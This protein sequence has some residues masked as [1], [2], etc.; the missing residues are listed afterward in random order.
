MY[1]IKEL[2]LHQHD[3]QTVDQERDLVIVFL[4]AVQYIYEKANGLQPVPQYES[5]INNPGKM[6]FMLSLV[7]EKRIKTFLKEFNDN[8]SRYKDLDCFTAINGFKTTKTRAAANYEKTSGERRVFDI[9][10]YLDLVTDEDGHIKPI[11]KLR[12]VSRESEKGQ[13]LRRSLIDF[14]NIV[15]SHG[16]EISR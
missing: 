4:S 7:D 13:D 11:D 5:W 10:G 12:L 1:F 14:K 2:D 15:D 16:E 6:N 9:S 8:F 3:T